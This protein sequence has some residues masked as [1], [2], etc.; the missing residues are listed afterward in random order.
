MR[1]AYVSSSKNNLRESEIFVAGT[2]IFSPLKFGV[3]LGLGLDLRMSIG[4]HY[5]V[6]RIDTDDRGLR[7]YFESLGTDILSKVI[8]FSPLSTWVMG[9]P[10]FN[11]GFGDDIPGEAEWRDTSVNNNGDI[12]RVFNTVLST[13]PVFFDQHPEAAI[14]V[15]GS[16]GIKD[17]FRKCILNCTKNCMVKCRK[18]G[19]RMSIYRSFVNKYY[20]LLATDYI[21]LG[22]I[23]HQ[24]SLRRTW[25]YYI[26]GKPYDTLLVFQKKD[27]TTRT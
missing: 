6:T 20:D 16:D 23:D 25:E 11:L 8:A 10:V 18:E 4:S 7:F 27:K 21:I 26:P 22:G 13:V 2:E 17:Y 12:Y 3:V 19:R 24:S 14:Q 9:R 5:E 15:R 1:W